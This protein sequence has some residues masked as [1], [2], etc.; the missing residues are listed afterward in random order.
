MFDIHE[1]PRHDHGIEFRDA[2]TGETL[3]SKPSA[4]VGRGVAMDID[5]RHRGCECWAA[6][7]GL[8]RLYDCRG[9]EISA[10]PRAC[11]MGVWW[12][13]DLLRELLDG[14]RI[15]KWDYERGQ[16]RLLLN[17]ADDGCAANNGSKANPCLVA[18]LFGD[19]REEIIWR[20]RDNRELRI[21]TT[22][23]PT[24]RR[25]VTLMHDPLYRLSVAWQNVGYNQPTQVGFYLGNGMSPP[26]RPAIR[27][28][29]R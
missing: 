7:P 28:V 23:A 19:W 6:G 3:W 29:G 16:A 26:P 9:R 11:N 13:G 27:T 12:D 8:D 15:E 22:T 14:V 2:R 4:D 18:D 5:P 20:S 21:F 10:K 17:A 24:E 1:H 25:M